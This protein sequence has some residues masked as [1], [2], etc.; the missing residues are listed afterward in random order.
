MLGLMIFQFASL[1]HSNLTYNAV[2]V[3]GSG[4]AHRRV[5]QLI[6]HFNLKSGEKLYKGLRNTTYIQAIA[7]SGQ[8]GRAMELTEVQLEQMRL[9]K[10]GKVVMQRLTH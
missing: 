10:K 9:G 3:D 8:D 5:R 2:P 1:K 6:V 7:F 4:A